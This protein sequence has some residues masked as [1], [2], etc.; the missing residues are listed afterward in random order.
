MNDKTSNSTGDGTD[1]MS[2][3]MGRPVFDLDGTLPHLPADK[4]AELERAL[5]VLFEEFEDV[6]LAATSEPKKLARILHVI[7]FGSFARGKWVEDHKSG[8]MS[9]YDLLVIVNSEFATDYGTYWFKAEER[10]LRDPKIGREVNFI[11][12]SLCEVNT[13]LKEGQYFFSDIRREGIPLY[14][15]SKDKAL[16]D[17]AAVNEAET[18][19]RAREYFDQYLQSTAEFIELAETSIEKSFEN[20]A[21]FL[22]HQAVESAYNCFL[23]VHTLY[24]PPSHNI[25]FLR[26]LAED[27]DANLIDAWPRASKRDRAAFELLKRAYIDARYSPK[28]EVT[29]EQLDWLVT[30]TRKLESAVKTACETKLGE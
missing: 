12:H 24:S 11:V 21:A 13:K 15:L 19:E 27:M 2:G 1:N 9:D 28:F 25:K 30:H 17:P 6:R 3:T 29:R 4:R 10:L 7:L 5:T 14:E 18:K 16:I 23:L 22:L 20:K 26:S 8:Y